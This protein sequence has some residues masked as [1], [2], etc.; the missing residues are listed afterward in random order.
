MD[1]TPIDGSYYEKELLKT[2]APNE[3]DIEKIVKTKTVKK[4]KQYL[5]KF[6]GWPDKYNRWLS[7]EEYQL[8]INK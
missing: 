6:I 7:E 5:V 4:Q 8:L 2:E 3:F 1:N